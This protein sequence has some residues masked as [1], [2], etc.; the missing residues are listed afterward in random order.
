VPKSIIPCPKRLS[1]TNQG[2]SVAPALT[3]LSFIQR[4]DNQRS[5]DISLCFGTVLSG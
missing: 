2:K 3:T 4:H 5:R 1:L